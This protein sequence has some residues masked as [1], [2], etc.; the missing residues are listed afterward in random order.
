MMDMKTAV[1]KLLR[2]GMPVP[3]IFKPI[4]RGFYWLGVFLVEAFIFIRKIFWVEP[5]LR[6]LCEKAGPGIRAECLPYVRGKGRLVVGENLYLS[7]RSCFY[8]SGSLDN[9]PEIIIGNDVF[10]GNRCTLSVA[11]KI[12]IGNNVYLSS[13]VRVHDK[14]DHPVDPERRRAGEPVRPDEVVP[15]VIE[16]NAW[17]GTKATILKGVR[18][19]NGAVVGA[20]SVVVS[21]V[22]PHTLVMGNPAKIIRKIGER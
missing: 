10:I 4:I 7:G 17:I 16:D 14:D 5:V 15:V 1:K 8:F 18:I 2:C 19:G 12:T 22:P 21:N 6:S 3:G 13:N 11:K 9:R 20:N